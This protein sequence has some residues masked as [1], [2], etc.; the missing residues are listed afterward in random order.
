MPIRHRF[1]VLLFLFLVPCLQSVVR[2]EDLFPLG[3]YWS[4][5]PRNGDVERTLELLQEHHCNFVWVTN[6]RDTQSARSFCELADKRG[7]RVGVLP[8]AVMHPSRR[9]Q[10]GTP[11]AA[12]DAARETFQ[13]FG[14]I[15]GIWG[16]VLD[17][18]PPI[19]AL[20]YLEALETELLR[21]DPTR[22]V[23]TVFRRTEAVP[24]IQRHRFGIVTYDCYPFGHKRDPNL[25]NTP[26]ASRQFYRRVTET[27][28]RHCEKRGVTFWVMPGAFQE[29]WGNQY[30]SEEMTLVAEAG[31]YLHWRMPTVGETRWQVWEAIAG[32]AKGVVYFLLWFGNTTHTS[33]TGA[34]PPKLSAEAGPRIEKAWD[35]EQPGALLNLDGTATRQMVAMGETYREVQKIVPV[36]QRLRFSSIP[37]IFPRSPLRTQTFQDTQGKI[38]AVVVN[39]DTDQPAEKQLEVLPGIEAVRD[40]RRDKELPLVAGARG[41]LQNTTVSLD[42]GGGT[43]LELDAN[44]AVRPLAKLIEDFSTPSRAVSL[45][46]AKVQITSSRWGTRWKHEVAPTGSTRP[47]TPADDTHL[48]GFVISKI[49]HNKNS[50]VPSGPMYVVYEGSGDVELSFSDDGQL[51]APAKDQGFQMPIPIPPRSTHV[52]FALQKPGSRL[53][54]I[55]TIAT[56]KP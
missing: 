31:A 28:G 6:L 47:E 1:P 41:G 17:D 3:V 14:D 39:D 56:E 35:T 52:R 15:Q 12:A 53:A 21:L 16:Y 7:I 29:I 8:E 30:W 50:L 37:V 25:P 18:E 54:R 40:L 48:P 20:P 44:V 24:A 32:G 11:Q 5:L 45:A 55:A 43:L 13:T 51:F 4:G 2:G 27:L 46:R 34:P 10:A 33:P 22:P 38:F 19:A 26:A 23:T 42:A 49:H 9:R 36:L